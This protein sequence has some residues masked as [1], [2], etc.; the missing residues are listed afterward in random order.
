MQ[1]R[2]LNPQGA[3]ARCSLG[4]WGETS[5][6]VNRRATQRVGAIDAE[7]EACE[8]GPKRRRSRGCKPKCVMRV[9]W[10]AARPARNN[11]SAARPAA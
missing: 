7:P 3:S 8:I 11:K 5:R 9:G 6:R 4:G 1:T 10:D 2:A